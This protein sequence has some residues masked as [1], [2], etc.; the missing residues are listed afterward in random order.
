M[1]CTESIIAGRITC[2]AR[3]NVSYETREAN[4]VEG[5]PGHALPLPQLQVIRG[6]QQPI[7]RNRNAEHRQRRHARLQQTQEGGTTICL[8]DTEHKAHACIPSE[9]HKTC[10]VCIWRPKREAQEACIFEALPLKHNVQQREVC[11]SSQKHETC[12]STT[13]RGTQ[14][15]RIFQV[16]LDERGNQQREVRVSSQ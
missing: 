8:T 15:V 3:V 10:E 16:S 11:V 5:Q 13:E 2:K 6:S 9:M 7:Q 1:A 14:R 12:V 4:V